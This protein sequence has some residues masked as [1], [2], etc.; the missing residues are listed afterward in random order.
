MAEIINSWLPIISA[1]VGAFVSAI[2]F[3][4]PY[5]KNAKAKRTLQTASKIAESVQPYIVEAE[6][7]VNYSGEEK[8]AYVLTKANQ[9]AIS[10][11]FKFDAV[12]VTEQ[13]E[14]LVALTKKVNQRDKDKEKE[15]KINTS[16]VA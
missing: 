6:K 9:F 4:I 8:L 16:I 5:I 3:L 2:S 15:N 13:I 7:F 12:A 11:G 10:N 1:V 14:N